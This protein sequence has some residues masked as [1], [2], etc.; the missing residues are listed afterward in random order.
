MEGRHSIQTLTC[1]L[2][3]LVA[4][5]GGLLH[6]RLLER[7]EGHVENAHCSES[8][9]KTQMTRKISVLRPRTCCRMRPCAH[10]ISLG[11]VLTLVLPLVLSVYVLSCSQALLLLLSLSC[12]GSHLPT[13]LPAIL[14]HSPQRENKLCLEGALG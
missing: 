7:L 14:P 2:P 13:V 9:V 4:S 11:F 1:L 10:V 5:L 8:T 12:K 6:K 3:L